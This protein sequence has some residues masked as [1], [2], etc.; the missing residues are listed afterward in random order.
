MLY[1]ILAYA[2]V[3]SFHAGVMWEQE[4][5][6]FNLAVLAV[7]ILCPLLLIIFKIK[8]AFESFLQW[9]QLPFF[10]KYLFNKKAFYGMSPRAL[11]G[12]NKEASKRNWFYKKAVLLINKVNNYEIP[13]G[14]TGGI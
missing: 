9:S 8:S 6:K 14:T 1:L 2:F 5:Q 10:F 4:G 11:E 7:F 3:G 13:K 12:I